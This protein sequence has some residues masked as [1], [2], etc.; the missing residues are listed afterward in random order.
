MENSFEIGKGRGIMC[1]QR[2]S[3]CM[4]FGCTSLTCEC[5]DTPNLRHKMGSSL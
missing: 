1:E 2:K 4:K 5:M 3:N